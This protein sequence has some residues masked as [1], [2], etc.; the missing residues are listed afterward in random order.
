MARRHRIIFLGASSRPRS[1]R[2]R[3]QEGSRAREA[4]GL[5][6]RLRD[7]LQRGARRRRASSIRTLNDN[8]GPGK[9]STAW[10]QVSYANNQ[11]DLSNQR[12]L[13]AGAGR[14]ARRATRRRTAWRACR[15]G[16]RT[17]ASSSASTSASLGG[18]PW[19]VKVVG[20]ASEWEP[21]AAMPTELRG[22]QRP[23]WLDGR[24]EALQVAIYKQIKKFAIPMKEEVAGRREDRLPK[25]DPGRSRMCPPARRKRLAALKDALAQARLRRAAR[26]SS[27]T[28]WCGASA[29]HR[30]PIPRWRR[31]R[32][33]RAR[34]IR[35]MR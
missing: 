9:I 22:A 5:R 10:H 15:R 14:A 7:R 30:A 16:S 1:R 33:T 19:R 24:T 32:P 8:P 20:H 2:V 28:T 4:L 11:D 25:T 26:R 35:W 3:Q 34:S 27:T 18:R 29:A 17:S 13:A 21:G 31:G 6:H 23:P 12:T